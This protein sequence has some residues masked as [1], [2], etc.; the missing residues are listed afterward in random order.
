MPLRWWL[1]VP[2][3]GAAIFSAPMAEII[4]LATLIFKPKFNNIRPNHRKGECL[5]GGVIW[6][7]PSWELPFLSYCF[8]YIANPYSLPLT[9]FLFKMPLALNISRIFIMNSSSII[10]LILFGISTFFITFL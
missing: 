1:A 9:A 5:L 4:A 8:G 2:I 7:F 10:L 3:F 6:Q